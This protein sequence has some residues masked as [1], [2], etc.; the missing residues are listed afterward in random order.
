MA[1]C[2]LSFADAASAAYVPLMRLAEQKGL[3]CQW[4][5]LVKNLTV[6]GPGGVARFHEGSEYIL[7]DQR[8]HRLSGEVKWMAGEPYAPE[9]VAGYLN[10][11]LRVES[12]SATPIVSLDS[13]RL[14]RIVLD[15][16]HGGHDQGANNHS[17]II[18]KDL[19]L[20]ITRR[21]A[22]R[23]RREGVEVI[24]TR[25]SDVFIPLE[26]RARISNDGNVD[27]F[28]SLHANASPTK[29]LKG[30]EVYT[31]SQAAGDEEIAAVRAKKAVTPRALFVDGAGNTVKAVYWDLREAEN[32]RE[33]IRMAHRI[34]RSARE[35]LD[36]NVLRLREAQFY[37]LKWTESPAVLIE[38]G[39]ITHP[40]DARLLED[41]SYVEKLCEALA[42]GILEWKKRDD[43]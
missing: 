21:V 23:L 42:K 10:R 41:E 16:G 22:E 7:I 19:V 9:E 4:E 1:V 40:D 24:L 29:S 27:L 20:K 15:A 37:V 35:S 33:S 25:D 18:E 30:F 3:S 5:P 17:G 34:G 14:R 6:Q 36:L 39:Y 31:L 26:E 12:Y 11:L 32:R 2:V 38:I 28:V 13:T 43:L 8:L